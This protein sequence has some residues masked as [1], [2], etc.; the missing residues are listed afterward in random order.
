MIANENVNI[1]S[2]NNTFQG[3]PPQILENTPPSTT[4]NEPP[5]DINQTN[6]ATH[7]SNHQ[8][9]NDTTRKTSNIRT[10]RNNLRENNS[11][12]KESTNDDQKFKPKRTIAIVGDL[13]V[14]NIYGPSY[15]DNKSNVFV[16]YLV[17]KQNA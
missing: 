1:Q 7:N 2:S 6:T 15:S 14:K 12:N 4:A 13:M 9:G 8:N 3:H 16:K 17:L 10:D 5:S 11:L